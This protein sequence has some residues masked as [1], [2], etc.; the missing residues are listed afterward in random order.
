[1]RFASRLQELRFT[2]GQG[3]KPRCSCQRQGSKTLC[4]I[5]RCR[6]QRVWETQVCKEMWESG[7]A[8]LLIRE[9]LM[10]DIDVHL[11]LV[12]F[13]YMYG[14]S[15]RKLHQAFLPSRS[16]RPELV[17]FVNSFS[18]EPSGRHNGEVSR[19]GFLINA[20]LLS[21]HISLAIFT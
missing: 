3:S 7:C 17:P 9:I 15:L 21:F 6:D 5:Q 13:M 1:M 4:D 10:D 16:H 8:S 19:R 14:C 11:Q 12:I 2:I 20:W 18:F